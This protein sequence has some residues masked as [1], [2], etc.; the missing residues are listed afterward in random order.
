MFCFY[1]KSD[2]VYNVPVSV[3]QGMGFNI[4]SVPNSREHPSMREVYITTQN[5][6]LKYNEY[7][8]NNY[9]DDVTMFQVNEN[10]FETIKMPFMI[11]KNKGVGYRDDI[12]LI[13]AISSIYKDQKR[14]ITI[15]IFSG[16]NKAFGDLM[17]LISVIKKINNVLKE[18]NIDAEIVLLKTTAALRLGFTTQAIYPELQQKML[19]ICLEELQSFDFLLEINGL[20]DMEEINTED[21]HD[22]YSTMFNFDLPED[23]NPEG[24]YVIR[25]HQRVL[26]KKKIKEMFNN[27]LPV[28]SVNSFSTTQIRTMPDYIKKELITKILDTG[29]FNIVSFDPI[30]KVMNVE[31]P[32]FGVLS[33]YTINFE[34]YASFLAATNGLISIDSAPIH[35]AARLGIPSFGIY[36]TINPKLREKYYRKAESIFL[37]NEYE[38]LNTKEDLTEE[39]IQNIWSEFDID[40][41]VKRIVKKFKK[42]IF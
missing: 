27:K 14:K 25:E 38:G 29:K 22:V 26:A 4:L 2:K 24:D 1:Q 33:P 13:E 31:H 8:T 32:N 35:L 30:A 15:A 41:A 40:S 39:D 9:K 12:E 18:K 19:P 34:D 20:L 17:G 36:T 28:L 21:I 10:V 11:G 7:I 5:D 37:K 16:A 42:G 3:M 6:A 23:F